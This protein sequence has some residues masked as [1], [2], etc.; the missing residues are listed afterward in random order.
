MT[1]A[2]V[3]V[4]GLFCDTTDENCNV[5]FCTGCLLKPPYTSVLT[6]NEFFSDTPYGNCSRLK[7]PEF[8]N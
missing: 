7:L 6:Y 2:I 8:T 4:C 1:E 5:S 3:N